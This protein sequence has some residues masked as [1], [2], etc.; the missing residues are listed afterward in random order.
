MSADEIT[1][2][3]AITDKMLR[4]KDTVVDDPTR[5][6][7]LALSGGGQW[8]AYG[9]GFLNGWT[10]D[11]SRP[12]F[13]VVTGV[14]TG[15]LI[16]PFAFLGADYDE[17]LEQGYTIEKEG[18]LVRERGFLA[19]LFGNAFLDSAGLEARLDAAI[20]DELITRIA[21]AEQN[22]GLFV[23]TV[24]ADSGQFFAVDLLALARTEQI[25]A[26]ER[27]ACFEAYLL[28]S[29]SIPASFPP[30]FISDTDGPTEI[31]PRMFVDGGARQTV[32]FE[33]IEMSVM[34]MTK[35][36]AEAN[37]YVI[38]NGDLQVPP[39]RTKNTLLGIANRA[40]SIVVD[41]VSLTSL[42]RLV[43]KGREEG[44]TV[45]YTT[46]RDHPCDA[47]AKQTEGEYFNPAFMSCLIAYG[48]QR[49]AAHTPWDASTPAN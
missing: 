15:A 48:K 39:S 32:F 27:E 31:Q 6:S 13:D 46:A 23:G 16:A 14:S 18:D 45:H 2:A 36:G 9:A 44:W 10:A 1:L 21:N 5:R 41:Q 20:D 7:L 11:Q 29:S 4:R 17:E 12:S 35:A 25:S 34:R 47:T 43:R 24:D 28:A 38:I 8:G 19:L 30:V 33:D 22:R 49:W 42:D 3:D 37:L 26:S 40:S